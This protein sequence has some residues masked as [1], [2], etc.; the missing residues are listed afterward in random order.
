MLGVGALATVIPLYFCAF[1]LFLDAALVLL[2]FKSAEL[3][4]GAQ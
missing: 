3:C 4:A 1:L 2:T